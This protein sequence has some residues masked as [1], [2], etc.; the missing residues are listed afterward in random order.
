VREELRR[1][2][3]SGPIQTLIRPLRK[4]LEHYAAL[5][6]WKQ[7]I[8]AIL[9]AH[10]LK[11]L[12]WEATFQCNLSC[13]HCGSSC[14]AKV[15][16]GL[17]T[18]QQ[19]KAAFQQI[20]ED[21]VPRNIVLSITGG[22]PLLRKDLAECCSAI[23]FHGFRAGIVTNGTL[24]TPERARE[25]VDAGIPH[26]AVSL[27]GPPD[28][29][30]W[31]RG[32]KGVY[33]RT[34][35]GITTLRETSGVRHVEVLSC[36]HPRTIDRLEET[37]RIVFD[38]GVGT[39]RLFIIDPIGRAEPELFLNRKQFRRLLDFVAERRQDPAYPI[40]IAFTEQG[41]LGF[42][43]E[44]SVRPSGFLCD[45]GIRTASVLYDGA[46]CGCPSMGRRLIEGNVLND[47]FADVWR[48]GFAICRN[49]TRE[50]RPGCADCGA[51]DFCR[52]GCMHLFD[53]DR[54]GPVH[55]HYK[56]LKGRTP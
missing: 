45:A 30:D 23:T 44:F 10:P 36:I 19:V 6:D 15:P 7:R 48:D 53:A 1:L 54:G 35:R 17:L 47:R 34:V 14:G 37:E 41:H 22:E 40:R 21:F 32:G 25:L 28:A 2:L 33:D 8:D 9:A 3:A 12:F 49:R 42:P 27:D 43:H 11:H 20:A 56:Q 16:P 26:Y 55:C 13:R 38:L 39:W 4:P 18:A 52:G 46:I 51:F 31:L 5:Y 24:A 50:G 29:H